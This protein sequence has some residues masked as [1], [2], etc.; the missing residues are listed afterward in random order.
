MTGIIALAPQYVY[1]KTPP[2]STPKKV[3]KGVGYAA[4]IGL[5]IYVSEPSVAASLT[6]ASGNKFKKVLVDT[7]A[8]IAGFDWSALASFGAKELINDIIDEDDEKLFTPLFSKTGKACA[9]GASIVLGLG[10]RL[11]SLPE[12]LK[13]N[14]KHPHFARGV[15]GVSFGVESWLPSHATFITI[16]R[17]FNRRLFEKKAYSAKQCLIHWT[18]NSRR[19]AIYM[20][21][22]IKRQKFQFLL[23]EM[24]AEIHLFMNEIWSNGHMIEHH[25]PKIKKCIDITS[26]SLAGIVLFSMIG[27]FLLD[28]LLAKSAV[29][30]FSHSYALVA[31]GIALTIIPMLYGGPK[32]AVEGAH[33]TIN[34]LTDQ[35]ETY[36]EYVFPISSKLLKI[37]ALLF[38]FTQ[39]FEQKALVNTYLHPGFMNNLLTATNTISC[40]FMIAKSYY[41]IIEAFLYLVAY[42]RK[43]D[44]D[45]YALLKERTDRIEKLLLHSTPAQ[46]LELLQACDDELKHAALRDDERT[47]L[48]QA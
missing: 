45:T 22:E 15:A 17:I 27:L 41:T 13:F 12:A 5:A 16:N 47:R 31:L 21:L 29:N 42:W 33:E 34:L 39:Y 1:S 44:S 9:I 46:M 10:Q 25:S 8:F 23:Q 40:G 26:H 20:S 24:P 14:K 3:V 18:A 32:I 36:G 11:P 4:G 48:I 38:S 19:S 7:A 43:Y 35:R 37:T 2:L 28:A 6:L 30:Y